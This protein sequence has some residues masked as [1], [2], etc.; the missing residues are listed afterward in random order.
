[1]GKKIE[2]PVTALNRSS[3]KTT[4][5][6]RAGRYRYDTSWQTECILP[7]AELIRLVRWT[8]GRRRDGSLCTRSI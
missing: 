2:K 7:S 3:F 8:T 5:S 1:V 4:A 6:T